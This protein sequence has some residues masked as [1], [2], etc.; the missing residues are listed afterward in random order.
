MSTLYL[1]DRNA[2]SDIKN[3]VDGKQFSCD[4]K[5]RF[6]RIQEIDKSENFVSPILSMIEGQLG[7]ECDKEELHQC[8]VKET[9]YLQ[10]FFKNANVDSEYLNRYSDD[11]SEVYSTYIE[12]SWYECY[13]VLKYSYPF[14][15]Q[16]LKSS[17]VNEYHKELFSLCRRLD[18]P[19]SHP[20]VVCC[21]AASLGCN[22][23]RNI[24]KPKLGIDGDSLNK[25]LYNTMTDLM[26]IPRVCLIKII[27]RHN[28]VNLKVE[29]LSFDVPLTKFLSCVLWSGDIRDMNGLALKIGYRKELFPKLSESKY[30]E[31]MECM[32]FIS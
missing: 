18:V 17:D 16:P 29:F 10:S 32:G 20:A 11:F 30:L 5:D 24:I 28:F 22:N 14:L 8:L 9:K 23:S 31:L 19:L 26:I 13:E 12:S 4:K 1:L 25:K 6:K 7:R 21:V 15:I 3:H 2:V 27:A